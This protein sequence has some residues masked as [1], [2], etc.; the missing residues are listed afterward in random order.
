MYIL[1]ISDELS[2]WI[3]VLA[4]SQK[5]LKEILLLLGKD[6]YIDSIKHIRYDYDGKEYLKIL[7]RKNK[8]NNL[9]FGK[10][11]ER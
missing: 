9:E 8:P 6:I 2:P 4:T 7:K 10:K 3:E 5:Q 11:K 1:T